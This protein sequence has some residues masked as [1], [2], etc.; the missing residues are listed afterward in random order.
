M[1][2]DGRVVRCSTHE[3]PDLF[4]ATCGGMGLTE[5]ILTVTFSMIPVESAWIRQE[6]IRTHSLDEMMQAFEDSRGWTYT[7]AWIDCHA[8]GDALG[9]GLLFRGEHATPGETREVTPYPTAIPARRQVSVPIDLPMTVLNRMT[10]GLFNEL[11]WQRGRPGTKLVPFDV[12]FY[13]L[14][15]V[16]NWNRIYGRRGFVQYQCVLPK[17][18]SSA[19]LR[20]LLDVAE[21]AGSGSFLAVLKLLGPQDGMLAFPFEGYT[22]ALDFPI[23][24]RL[25]PL[26]NEMDQIVVEHGGRLYLAKDSRSRPDQIRRGYRRLN[27]FAKVRDG[28]DSTHRFSSL[29]SERL[30]L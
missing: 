6:T 4:E 1:L 16:L 26:L 11:Y 15:S 30:A 28:F 24:K 2:A 3:N 10:V 5:L 27:E 17:N 14:D 9:R 21:R 7:V 22:M 25:T 8:K 19:G 12:F 18:E 23:S 20:R 13:P 29:L